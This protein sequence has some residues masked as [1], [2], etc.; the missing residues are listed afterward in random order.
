MNRTIIARSELQEHQVPPYQK[1]SF[2]TVHG[3][4]KE[5]EQDSAFCY[6]K[7]QQQKKSG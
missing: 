3:H 6:L 7:Q 1:S 4:E 5:K 2:Q